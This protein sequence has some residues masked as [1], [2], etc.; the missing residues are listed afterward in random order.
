MTIDYA[1]MSKKA[2]MNQEKDSVSFDEG[3]SLVYLVPFER[4]FPAGMPNV[5][6]EVYGG[7]VNQAFKRGVIDYGQEYAQSEQ[8]HQ[9]LSFKVPDPDP[10]AGWTRDNLS[11]KDA[12]AAE[13]KAQVLW[14]VCVLKHR[15]KAKDSWVDVYTKPK[16]MTA[17]RGNNTKPHIQSGLEKLFDE[18]P[19]VV[20]T[21]F[22]P[23]AAQLVIIKRQGKGQY[24]TVFHVE[25]ASG[26][27]AEFEISEEIRQDI[28]NAT[29]PGAYCDLNQ[30]V[31]DRFSAD[32]E[33]IDKKLFGIGD[34]DEG[35]GKSGPGMEE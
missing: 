4:G 8:Y 9:A 15:R 25:L 31:A 22:N 30:V 33:E 10:I 2:T 27:F 35:S 5:E 13:P 3:D 32:Q 18:D 17:K 21:L 16:W 12:K 1:A 19:S 7:K 26:E 28:A 11:G 14:A 23:D 34:D 29:K 20:P 24:D 6:V